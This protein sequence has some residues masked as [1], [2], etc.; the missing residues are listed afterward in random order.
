MSNDITNPP[1]YD[2]KISP[3]DFILANDLGFIQ[4][5]IVKYAVRVGKKG[6]IHDAISDCRKIQAY[7]EQLVMALEK[8]KN[9]S[10]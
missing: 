10:E 5:N 2:M 1:H 7:A 6:D 8:K 9:V 3:I 4:G